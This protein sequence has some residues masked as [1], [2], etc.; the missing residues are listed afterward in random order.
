MNNVVHEITPLLYT[1]IHNTVDNSSYA[2][3]TN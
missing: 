3:S 1:S 2:K